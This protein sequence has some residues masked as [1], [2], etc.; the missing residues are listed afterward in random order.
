MPEPVLDEVCNFLRN[1]VRSG[2][3]LEIEFLEGVTAADG[4]FEILEPTPDDRHRAL[5][6]CRRLASGPLGYVD[7]IVLAMAEWLKVPD[8]A[9]VDYKFL[10]MAGPVSRLQPLNWVLLTQ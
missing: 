1:H 4:D 7:G 9:T 3:I 8:I 5:E 6:L 10:G 2:P